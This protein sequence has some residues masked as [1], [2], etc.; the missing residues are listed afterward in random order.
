MI[1]IDDFAKLEIKIG[2]ILSV[3]KIPNADKLLKLSVDVGEESPRQILSG[4]AEYFPDPE[5]L[6]GRQA[7]FL[8]NIEPRTL[9]GYVSH[10]MILAVGGEVGLALL[11]PSEKVP[12]GSPIK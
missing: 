4:I 12:N 3:E 8:L 11:N 9:R 6:V 1:N 10:G 5:D 2:E 7:P